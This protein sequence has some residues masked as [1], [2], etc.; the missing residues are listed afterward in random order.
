MR[1]SPGWKVAAELS[2]EL[3][4]HIL[5]YVHFTVHFWN[6]EDKLARFNNCINW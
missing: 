5:F 6:S 3:Q 1:E 4:K 2:A